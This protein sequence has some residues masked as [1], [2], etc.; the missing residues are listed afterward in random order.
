MW[1]SYSATLM[2]D[3]FELL[4]PNMV[5]DFTL[6]DFTL[7]SPIG[8]FIYRSKVNVASFENADLPLIRH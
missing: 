5:S 1:V 2:A 7:T 8:K 4:S 6:S 3:M